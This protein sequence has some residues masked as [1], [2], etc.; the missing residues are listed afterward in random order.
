MTRDEVRHVLAVVAE[1]DHR[2][3]PDTHIRIWMLHAGVSA[4]DLATTLD[5]VAWFYDGGPPK[6]YPHD[7]TGFTDP[8]I[9]GMELVEQFHAMRRALAAL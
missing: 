9:F 8:G 1:H 2:V 3:N 6:M 4:W 5:A 7:R